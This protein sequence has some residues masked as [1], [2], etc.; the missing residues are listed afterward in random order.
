MLTD[1]SDEDEEARE[2][3]KEEQEL[4]MVHSWREVEGSLALAEEEVQGLLHK[5]LLFACH[6]L[7]FNCI[8]VTF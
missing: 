7:N 4:G 5:V 6:G 8:L 2:V 3:T 1:K